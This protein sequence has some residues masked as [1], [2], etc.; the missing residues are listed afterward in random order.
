MVREEILREDWS[1]FFN[2]F[3]NQHRGAMVT[4]EEIDDNTGGAR[5][6]TWDLALENVIT[7]LDS[8]SLES[9]AIIVSENTKRQITYIIPAPSQITLEQTETG[10]GDVLYLK[11]SNGVTT[12]LRFNMEPGRLPREAIETLVT[13]RSGGNQH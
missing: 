11:S 8:T 12:L 5:M 6:L 4:L 9:V 10:K 3:T 7:N 1:V 2:T 13:S